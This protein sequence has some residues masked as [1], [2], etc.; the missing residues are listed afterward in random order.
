VKE[1]LVF[2]FACGM[3]A[4]PA[5]PAWA[6]STDV[7]VSSSEDPMFFT[8]RPESEESFGIPIDTETSIGFTEDGEPALS[9]TY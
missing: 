7:T 3:A 6:R 5:S 9:R 8:E 2:T 1:L 4:L